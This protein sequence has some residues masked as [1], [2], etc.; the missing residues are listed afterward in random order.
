M[1]R[2]KRHAKGVGYLGPSDSVRYGGCPVGL[3]YNLHYIRHRISPG[4]GL[5][6]GF[7]FMVS[8]RRKLQLVASFCILLLAAVAVSCHGFFVDPT[9]TGMTVQTLN[10]S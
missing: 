4:K 9:L 10:S 8:T 3:C 6:R 2:T 5:F 1:V 7:W